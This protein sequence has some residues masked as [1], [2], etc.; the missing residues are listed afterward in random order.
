[1]YRIRLTE[2]ALYP[3]SVA[4]GCY[5]ADPKEISWIIWNWRT[6]DPTADNT[7][8]TH[9]NAR[10]CGNKKSGDTLAGPLWEGCGESRRCSRDIY[11]ESNT[12][13]HTSKRRVNSARNRVVACTFVPSAVT[14]CENFDDRHEPR[15]V[16]K[17]QRR[18]V[19][20]VSPNFSIHPRD[21]AS[22]LRCEI[23][24]LPQG[25]GSRS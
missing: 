21:V 22:D 14:A 9:G 17:L 2:D 16:H 18:R 8:V 12:N 7:V 6:L 3:L 19:R 20:R 11:P 15:R 4:A 10:G 13:K 25:S 23:V 1:M 24:R 5:T